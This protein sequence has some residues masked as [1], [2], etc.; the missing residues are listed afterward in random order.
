M[1]KSGLDPTKFHSIERVGGGTRIHKVEKLI[2]DA[3][4][5]E[6]VSKTLDATESI[7]RGCAI[8]AAMLSK[9]YSVQPFRIKEMSHYPINIQMGYNEEAGTSKAL[10]KVGS[11]YDRILSLSI[12]K[13]E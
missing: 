11:Y 3:F 9:R 7:S 10:F 2:K 12:K 5:V 13:A 6:Q 1:K 8:Q 4:K